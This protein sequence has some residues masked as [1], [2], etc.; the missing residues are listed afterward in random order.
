MEAAEWHS[1][2]DP[3]ES[4]VKSSALGVVTLGEPWSGPERPTECPICYEVFVEDD[5]L[6]AL[7]CSSSLCPS[8]YHA[9][10]IQE[11]LAKDASCPLCRRDFPGLR[12]SR[13]SDTTSETDLLEALAG[14]L[15]WDSTPLFDPPPIANRLRARPRELWLPARELGRRHRDG[16]AERDRAEPS[17]EPRRRPPRELGADEYSSSHR[18]QET[19]AFPR[20]RG[21]RVERSDDSDISEDLRPVL[22]RILQLSRETN[23]IYDAAQARRARA[24]VSLGDLSDIE[25]STGLSFPHEVRQHQR[26]LRRN[27][28]T[29]RG[30][31]ERLRGEEAPMGSWPRRD[32]AMS[33]GGGPGANATSSVATISTVAGPQSLGVAGGVSGGQQRISRSLSEADVQP[34][35]SHVSRQFD[36]RVNSDH[37]RPGRMRTE[38]DARQQL[39]RSRAASSSRPAHCPL[40]AMHTPAAP[41]TRRDSSRGLIARMRALAGLWR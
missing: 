26:L 33:M 27:N 36:V 38:M 7:P 11:W 32:D 20:W 15:I 22:S 30:I 23:L 19:S 24:V 29:A 16:V 12:P 10:C 4:V 31:G 3:K 17:A 40:D 34:W 8:I 28:D 13:P 14:A 25:D 9:S 39:G 1:H 5:D 18:W 35:A 41:S 37:H 6:R 21:D 2:K